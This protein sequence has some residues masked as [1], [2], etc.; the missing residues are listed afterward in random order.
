MGKITNAFFG[1]LLSVILTL[2]CS[3]YTTKKGEEV[4][5]EGKIIPKRLCDINSID[6]QLENSRIYSDTTKGMLSFMIFPPPKNIRKVDCK[7]IE[8]ENN[9]Y[10]AI[11]D[12]IPESTYVSPN[13]NKKEANPWDITFTHQAE[14]DK[15]G[16]FIKEKI[17]SATLLQEP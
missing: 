9:K 3:L 7:K 1:G 10:I 4:F 11:V 5:L 14:Y 2:S 16:K 8:E 13:S 12:I 17:I 6:R 15:N